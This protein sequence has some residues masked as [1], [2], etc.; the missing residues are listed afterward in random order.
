MRELGVPIECGTSA[1]Q[2]AERS[3]HECTKTTLQAGVPGCRHCGGFVEVFEANPILVRTGSPSES[4][5]T[6]LGKGVVDLLQSD[7]GTGCG[8]RPADDG[9]DLHGDLLVDLGFAGEVEGPDQLVGD[10]GSVS[11]AGV[12]AHR[13]GV[14]RVDNGE[15]NVMTSRQPSRL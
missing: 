4:G 13:V 3:F 11:R 6:T 8:K 14:P 10:T 7:L 2:F 12:V 5:K 1:K 15:G 9:H